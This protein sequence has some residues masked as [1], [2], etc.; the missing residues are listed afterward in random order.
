MRL[1]GGGANSEVWC[2]IIADILGIETVVPEESELGAKGAFLVAA[3]GIGIYPSIED[4]V[5]ATVSY[6][7]RYSPNPVNT[8]LYA[9]YYGLY[10]MIYQSVW[11]AWDLRAGIL[12]GKI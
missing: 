6:K 2:Q 1:A 8:K 5:D 12:M 9:K 7:A 10:K 3:T 11:N 4:A